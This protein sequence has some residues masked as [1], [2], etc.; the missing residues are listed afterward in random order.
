MSAPAPVPA[1]AEPAGDVEI[2]TRIDACGLRCPG[3]IMQVAGAVENIAPGQ[4][5]SL[6]TGDGGFAGD[7]AGW[8]PLNDG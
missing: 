2:V 3:P 8:M 5:V 7:I 6:V 1:A 4:G